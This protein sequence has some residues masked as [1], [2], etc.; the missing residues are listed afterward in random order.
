[1]AVLFFTSWLADA[2]SM[3]AAGGHYN[4]TTR[5]EGD[6]VHDDSIRPRPLDHDV[7]AADTTVAAGNG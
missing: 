4:G 2:D 1:M 7:A 5:N 6:F 3:L